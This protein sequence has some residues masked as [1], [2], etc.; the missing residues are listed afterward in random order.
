MTPVV[1]MLAL[2]AAG[3]LP[4]QL[5]SLTA[6]GR[7]LTQAWARHDFTTLTRGSGDILILLPGASG[8]AALRAEQAAEM[9]RGFTAG[10][11]ELAVEMVVARDV[12]RDRAY[13]EVER[14]FMVRGTAARHRQT[15]YF[16]LR[17]HGEGYRLYEVRIVS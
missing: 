12:D 8:A 6:V 15:V 16:G 1:L 13:V 7:R 10:A 4:P 2:Q 11:H 3:P 14:V 9:L 5:D 17:R